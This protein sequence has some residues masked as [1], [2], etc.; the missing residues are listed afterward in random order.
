MKKSTRKDKEV[1]RAAH[2]VREKVLSGHAV[3]PYPKKT[4]VVTLPTPPATTIAETPKIRSVVPQARKEKAGSSG[5]WRADKLRNS[6]TSAFLREASSTVSEDKAARIA[7]DTILEENGME[8]GRWVG[9]NPGM[10]S[11]NL[12]NVLD[13]LRRNNGFC[14]V[15][16]KKILAG[17]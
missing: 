12:R 10:L 3:K 1:S 13:G 6:I 2:R 7:T 17:E 11:M 8:P 4:S 15:Y 14:I 16:G 9:K 5:V